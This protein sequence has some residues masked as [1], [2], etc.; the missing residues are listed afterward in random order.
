LPL[1]SKRAAGGEGGERRLLQLPPGRHGLP[2][3][4]VRQHQRDRIA[5]S[6][7]ASVAERGYKETTITQIADAAGVS[8]RTFYAYFASKDECFFD[9]FDLIIDHLRKAAT[10]AAAEHAEWPER[11]RARLAAVLDIFAANP[12]LARFVL[13]SSPRA[14]AEIA[15]RYRRA[16]DE[17]LAQMTEGMPAELAGREPS[18]EEEHALVGGAAAIIVRRV[19]AGKGESL[20]ELLPDL[21]EFTLTPFLGRDA[22]SR[23]ARG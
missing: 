2:R 20:P 4:F 5:A 17:A 12:D 21:V 10:E 8:R 3:E 14:G 13:I 22:A 9:T 18:L 23:F 19:E 7:I 16:M 6:M 15:A 11:V 1:V